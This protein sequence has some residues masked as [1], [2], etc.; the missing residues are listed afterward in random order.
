MGQR[1]AMASNNAQTF[2]VPY[3]GR[4][5]VQ[6]TMRLAVSRTSS[7]LRLVGPTAIC[8]GSP[9]AA[10]IT[11]TCHSNCGSPRAGLRSDCTYAQY[12]KASWTLHCFC[13]YTFASIRGISWPPIAHC[14]RRHAQIV[15]ARAKWP[16][17]VRETG[18]IRFHGPSPRSAFNIFFACAPHLSSKTNAIAH[19]ASGHGLAMESMGQC[20]VMAPNNSKTS[21]VPL[22]HG[23]FRVTV[24]KAY[25]KPC[26][27]LSTE[28]NRHFASLAHCRRNN[29]APAASTTRGLATRTAPAVCWTAER[30]RRRIQK[31]IVLPCWASTCFYAY[32]AP[33][34]RG[35][36]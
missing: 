15:M 21:L 34:M 33:S 1:I 13:L 18:D 27:L 11:G 2:L 19:A 17:Q 12:F 22:V 14:F 28:I 4:Q 5:G 20:V 8:N 10:A 3:D 26:A 9:V 30:L 6:E 32:V 31:G 25:K 16:L 35:T 36:S 24:D 29:M 23:V 7:P